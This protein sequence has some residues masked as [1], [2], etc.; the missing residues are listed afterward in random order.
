MTP[1]GTAADFALE[2]HRRGFVPLFYQEGTKGPTEPGWPERRYS[3]EELAQAG[4]HNVG[5]L[6]GSASGG[7]TDVDLDCPE[8]L[9][10]APYFLPET[11]MLFGRRS[12]PNSHRMYTSAPVPRSAVFKDLAGEML[13]ELRT[14][15]HQTMAP[16]SRHPC[17][18]LVQWDC[19]E[20]PAKVQGST[21]E[22]SVR[23]L[24]GA[25]ILARHWPAQGSRQNAAL[26]LA[27]GLLRAG[28]ATERAGWFVLRVASAA[29]DEEAEKRGDAAEHTARKLQA[30]EATTGWR[31][32]V[33]FMGA[34]V[35][36][37]VCEWIGASAETD[38]VTSFEQAVSREAF[39]IRARAE[40][41]RRVAAESALRRPFDAALLADSK[42][43]PV[44]WRV[45]GLLP[46]RGRLLLAAQRKAGKTTEELNLARDLIRGEDHLGHFHVEAI[47]GRAALLN[48]EVS[49]SQICPWAREV[50]I[51]GDRLLMVHLRGCSNPFADPNDTARLAELMHQYNVE[52]IFVDPFGRAYS[53]TNQNDAGEVGAWLADLD[54][55]VEAAGAS[56]L[57]LTTHA[58]WDG[59]RARG[60][61]ALED[62]ADAVAYIVRDKEDDRLRYFRAF[63]RDVE[64][65]EDR[66]NF[67]PATR[68]LTLAGTGNRATARTQH[69]VEELIA[70]V[71]EA[72][73]R[74]P[75]A[76]TNRLEALLRDAGLGLQRGDAGRAA[77]AAV[78]AGQIVRVPGARNSFRHYLVGH[79]GE[80][81]RVVPTLP[82][83]S[84]GV[85]PTP[86]YRGRTTAVLLG[87][88]VLPGIL[89]SSQPDTDREPGDNDAE[90]L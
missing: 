52:V 12:K 56:E 34:E 59:E 2:Y 32:L 1:S 80:S 5:L 50:G 46:K 51:P 36:S 75:G 89:D 53:G 64:I 58:G 76:T 78:E 26:A 41:H 48:F 4:G 60:S 9:A 44:R 86:P 42:V 79:E 55:F 85:V 45:E 25:C 17:G 61:S 67:D 10:L 35:V 72:V 84:A 11:G 83:G 40:A 57:I 14:D 3:P 47:T 88:A 28:W 87:Q 33:E 18:E 65:E 29:G 69:R 74:D 27:G 90:V 82:A 66:L 77:R 43:E 73:T 19:F 22:T 23:E 81:S 15:R 70:G 68:R 24:A 54:R 20:D 49:G 62:W 13:V 38:E 30:G 31:S 37:K 16:P 39:T 63:G 71:V 7:L 6:T 21:L 8:A